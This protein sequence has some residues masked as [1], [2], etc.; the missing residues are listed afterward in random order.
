MG[1][2]H[3]GEAVE[4]VGGVVGAGVGFGVV[5]DAEDGPVGVAEAFEGL[6][7]EVFVGG[8]AADGFE[9]FGVDGEAVV[10]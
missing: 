7:V 5:L 4:Q 3:L 8:F 10:L 9:G 1:L 6:V 2:E